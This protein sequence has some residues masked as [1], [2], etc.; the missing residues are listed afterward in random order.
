MSRLPHEH[1]SPHRLTGSEEVG[2]HRRFR[3][4]VD[5]LV[6]G[7]GDEASQL[8]IESPDTA[9]VV[10][11]FEDGSTILVRQ[12]RHPWGQTSWEVPA[13]TLEEGEDALVGARRELEEEAGLRAGRW[14]PLGVTRA[15]AALTTRQHLF[16]AQDLAEVGRAPELY[17]QDMV[18]HRLP[19]ADALAEALS[20]GIQHSGSVAALARAGQQLR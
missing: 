2:G 1:E 8:V 5:A 14:T 16:L 10:P 6:L 4:R 19:F 9:L 20:G 17:E 7:S 12:W 15:S 3:L 13:G 11:V 18:V